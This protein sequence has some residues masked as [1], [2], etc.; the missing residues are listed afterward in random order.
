M[1]ILLS[2]IF[3]PDCNANT[4]CCDNLANYFSSLGHE[5]DI[6]ARQYHNIPFYEKINNFDI[7]RHEFRYS[8]LDKY[9]TSFKLKNFTNLQLYSSLEMNVLIKQSYKQFRPYLHAML[10]ADSYPSKD[11]INRLNSLNKHY[12]YMFAFSSP[13]SCN[14]LAHELKK[15]KI[16]DHWSPIMLDAYV[17]N[18]TLESK[19]INVR[20][21]ITEK[22]FSNAE[23]IFMVYGIQQ[24]YLKDNYFPDYY[25]NT[26]TINIPILKNYQFTSH[27]DNKT[28]TLIYT[29]IFYWNIRNPEKM[30]NILSKI[31]NINFKVYSQNCDDI[32]EYY[33]S[34]FHHSTLER[35][36]RI[37]HDQCLNE[38]QNAD[39]LI[40]LGNT[41]TNQ[42]PSKILEYI[43][44]GK[45]I[46]HFYFTDG[47]LCLNVLKKYPLCLLIDLNHYD[48]HDIEKINQFIWQNKNKQL[49][50]EDATANL[51]DFKIEN[52]AQKILSNL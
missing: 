42:M 41:V 33:Q 51:E 14:R 34:L 16:V 6:V 28:P 15:A 3:Y 47:D 35:H 5:V 12:D 18:K 50:Y 43:S 8:F 1:K 10:Y 20:K 46:I 24:E 32:L 7:I 4:V 17:Y 49:S 39:I 21:K 23:K 26:I 9:N 25:K 38:I 30:L 29:G 40:S 52:I 2:V 36:G 44:T 11:L 19:F 27:H 22:V 48:E 31:D 37:S 45:P 13:F